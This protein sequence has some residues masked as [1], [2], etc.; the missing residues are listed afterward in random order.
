MRTAL[1]REISIEI[2]FDAPD[3]AT[4]S[5]RISASSPMSAPRPALVRR[6]HRQPG[7]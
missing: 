6:T 7:Q 4:L 1:G 5:D 2:L 3:I